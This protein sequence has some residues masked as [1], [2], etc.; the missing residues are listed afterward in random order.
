MRSAAWGPMVPCPWRGPP[1]MKSMRRSHGSK[2]LFRDIMLHDTVIVACCLILLLA[3][4]SVEEKKNQG[5]ERG[6]HVSSTWGP[7]LPFPGGVRQGGVSH[8]EVLHGP[9][10]GFRAGNTCP[11]E[12]SHG[13]AFPHAGSHGEICYPCEFTWRVIQKK[14]NMNMTCLFFPCF[15]SQGGRV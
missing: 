3:G 9:C 7:S 11:C 2:P 1:G 12:D 6:R 4:G 14:N 10:T 5:R 13:Q 15:I 8:A